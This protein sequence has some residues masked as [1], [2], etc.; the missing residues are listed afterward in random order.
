MGGADNDFDRF[1]SRGTTRK[2]TLTSPESQT[3]ATVWQLHAGQPASP[4]KTPTSQKTPRASRQRTRSQDKKAHDPV[5]DA[6]IQEGKANFFSNKVIR[7]VKTDEDSRETAKRHRQRETEVDYELHSASGVSS[8]DNSPND[9]RVVRNDEDK[10]M[11]KS[12]PH[13][14]R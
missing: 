14:L 4:T 11:G 7:R 1:L 13:C 10:W 3:K 12:S 2:L 9:A 6:K 8:G 5:E